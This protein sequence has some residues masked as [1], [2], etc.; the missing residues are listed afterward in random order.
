MK[1]FRLATMPYLDEQ[2]RKLK[3]V[4]EF[5]AR[6]LPQARAWQKTLRAQ[7]VKLLGGFPTKRCALNPRE[8]ERREFPEVIRKRVVITTEP[9]VDVPIYV[10][11]P[12]RA[13]PPYRV[14]LANHGHEPLG[15]K[16][17]AAVGAD[18]VSLAPDQYSN[19]WH[20]ALRGYLALCI[21][22]RAFAERMDEADRKQ[23]LTTS[24]RQV[25]FKAMMMGRT[26]I[27]MRVWDVMRTID[28]IESLKDAD[29]S[30]IACVGCSG[31]G[32]I[33][34]F[35][36]ALE[37]RIRLAVIS[38]YFCTFFHSVMSIHHCECNYVPGIVKYAEMY[39]IAG[40][41]APKPLLVQ[42]GARD[43][44]FP[45]KAVRHAF[46]RLK[47]IYRAFGAGDRVAL[48]VPDEPHGWNGDRAYPFTDKWL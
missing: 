31:G 47:R 40:L 34:T 6:T 2:Y 21:E 38:C 5:R 32:T 7:L 27:G 29:A 24:C 44:L 19:G 26:A 42:A 35:A 17:G 28:Y 39:E 18:G 43:K 10:L 11:I 14:V 48:H 9:G 20:Y 1:S 30:R 25:S 23:G 3:R 8:V 4:Y 36:A 37:P 46:G 45:V 41:F 15:S 22:H 33:T 16:S 13:K 12:K